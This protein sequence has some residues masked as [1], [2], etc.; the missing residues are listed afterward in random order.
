MIM[1]G[2]VAPYVGAWIETYYLT[3]KSL[4]RFVAPYVG[5]WIETP[6][7]L[8]QP[9]LRKSLPTWERGLKRRSY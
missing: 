6:K 2:T 1:T 8:C 9:A 7:Q 5:A 4:E 3:N